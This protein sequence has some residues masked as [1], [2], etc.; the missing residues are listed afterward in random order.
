MAARGRLQQ[1]ADTVEAAEKELCRQMGGLSH[2]HEKIESRARQV[3][4]MKQ[5]NEDTSPKL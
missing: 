3:T 1:N 5:G 4:V 2:F